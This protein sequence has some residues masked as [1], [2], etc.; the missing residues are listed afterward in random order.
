[1]TI[2][3]IFYVKCDIGSPGCKGTSSYPSEEFAKQDGWAFD[4]DGLTCCPDC[5][6][7]AAISLQSL[8]Y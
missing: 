6:D 5:H 7:K 8:E 1:M 2:W 3:W 4:D